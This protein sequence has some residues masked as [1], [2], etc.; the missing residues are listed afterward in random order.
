MD[1]PGAEDKL[2]ELKEQLQNPEGDFCFV[3]VEFTGQ[4]VTVTNLPPAHKT[5]N[6]FSLT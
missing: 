3:N 4:F 5:K 6:L 2:S 1:L